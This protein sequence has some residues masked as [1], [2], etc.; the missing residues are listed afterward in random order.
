MENAGALIIM[1]HHHHHDPLR[2][3][4]E[5]VFVTILLP[6]F[7]IHQAVRLAFSSF[8]DRVCIQR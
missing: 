6:E 5:P 4:R 2:N 8:G 3:G 1:E 7:I